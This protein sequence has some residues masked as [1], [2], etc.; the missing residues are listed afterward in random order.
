M[1]SFSHSLLN[2][3]L[4]HFS[5]LELHGTINSDVLWL[6]NANKSEEEK[7]ASDLVPSRSLKEHLTATKH[8][9]VEQGVSPPESQ[10]KVSMW[11]LGPLIAQTSLCSQSKLQ[12]VP[13]VANLKPTST[14]WF[15][16]QETRLPS[17][18]WQCYF[19]PKINKNYT[20]QALDCNHK[21]LAIKLPRLWS[22]LILR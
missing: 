20:Q 5:G 15:Q 16:Y 8:E 12:Q 10:S 9:H 22:L 1:D 4:C 2:M 3:T 17:S 14:R 11:V 13:L 18:G 7:K 6:Q 21:H 19:A